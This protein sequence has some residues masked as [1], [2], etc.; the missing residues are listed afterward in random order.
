MNPG[1][2]LWTFL[3]TPNSALAQFELAQYKYRKYAA[4]VVFWL[5][6]YILLFADRNTHWEM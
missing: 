2:E 4:L 3:N 1:S 6:G 5:V